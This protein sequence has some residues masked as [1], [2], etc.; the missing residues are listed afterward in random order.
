MSKSY[1]SKEKHNLFNAR[2]TCDDFVVNGSASVGTTYYGDIR[3]FVAMIFVFY[4]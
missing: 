3:R 4:K 2:S 1:I